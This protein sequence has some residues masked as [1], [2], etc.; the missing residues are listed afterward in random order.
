[1]KLSASL[2]DRTSKVTIIYTMRH[3]RTQFNTE[4]RYAGSIDV[5]LDEQG[6]E[7]ARQVSSRFK[8]LDLDVAITSKLKRSIQTASLLL[9]NSVPIVQS[10]LC[11]E[12]NFGI[13]EGRTWDEIQVLQPPVMLIQVGNDL[14]SVNPKGG[15][16]L[17]DVWA[18]AKR[19]RGFIFAHYR[20]K[21]VLVISH[22]VFLQMFHGLLRGLNCIES[23]AAYPANLELARFEFSGRHLIRESVDTL[24]GTQALRW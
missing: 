17:E 16:A 15:E 7:D 24:N 18:R 9:E 19:F 13:M 23:L 20:G 14:H 1:M 10:A 22:G 8:S 21:K 6:T 11:A 2:R 3:A 12:R 4:R 5:E